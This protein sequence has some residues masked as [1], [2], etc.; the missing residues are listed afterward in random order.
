MPVRILLLASVLAFVGCASHTVPTDAL[1]VANFVELPVPG[2]IA[3]DGINGAEA[4]ILAKTYFYELLGI[5]CGAVNYRTETV[6]AWVFSTKVGY[7][8]ASGSDIIVRKDGLCVYRRGG[9]DL[10]F[11]HGKWV[12][13]KRRDPN[14]RIDE[15]LRKEVKKAANQALQHNDPSCHVSCLRTP[16]ASWG[17][18]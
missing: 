5:G 11:Y 10:Y 15:I 4:E 16:R 2:V 17:R 6:I 1:T 13:D 8:N 7:E 14:L 12:Y 9:P 3:D 18:G